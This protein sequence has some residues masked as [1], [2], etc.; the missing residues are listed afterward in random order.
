MPQILSLHNPREMR[1]AIVQER[2][3]KSENNI[4]KQLL[5]MK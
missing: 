5:G 1:I 3:A 4:L 2:E